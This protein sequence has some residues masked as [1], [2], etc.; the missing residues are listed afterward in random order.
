MS[1]R[2]DISIEQ[3]KE[4]IR[5][6]LLEKKEL[7][8]DLDRNEDFISSSL[9]PAIFFKKR[10][11]NYGLRYRNIIN[12]IPL[13]GSIS[14]KLYNFLLSGS[15]QNANPRPS[16][17]EK[18][19][20]SSTIKN[21]PVLGSLITWAYRLAKAPLR[22]TEL[23]SEIDGL[24]S[25]DEALEAKISK[26]SSLLERF[27]TELAEFIPVVATEYGVRKTTNQ[28]SPIFIHSLWR[29]GST[30][31]WSKFRQNKNCY[32]YYEPFNELL[33]NSQR[34]ALDTLFC[35]VAERMSH[36][37]LEKEYFYESPLL[38]E[39]GNAF[40]RKSFP[41][42]DYCLS[43]DQQHPKLKRYIK[44]LVDHAY[45]KNRTP[46]MQF[47]RSSLRAKWLK[48]NFK[49]VNI[50]LLRFPRAQWKS[51]LSASEKYFDPA[52]F[53]IAGKNRFSNLIKPL[54]DVVA[55]PYFDNDDIVKELK[56]YSD[57]LGEYSLQERYFVFYYIW[58]VSL[59]EVIPLCDLI[60]DMDL[61]SQSSNIRNDVED[62]LKKY[63]ITVDFHDCNIGQYSNF[64][65]SIEEMDQIEKNVQALISQKLKTEFE[66][67]TVYFKN[68]LPYISGNYQIL[69]QSI[70]NNNFK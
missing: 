67:D 23:H 66:K 70:F 30:Y 54:L 33:L 43:E 61:M 7:Y 49:S 9:R 26:L 52:T 47:C 2:Q 59:L 35:N 3:I 11:I 16:T 24:K 45:S 39:G 27:D 8:K 46:V 50:Y 69:L 29:T 34:S 4:K 36:S 1:T 31:I 38:K 58:L 6:S 22:I 56:F 12:K 62:F 64:T 53:L 63:S 57:K 51:Y 41:Y 14:K 25:R 37:M 10:I 13:L 60:I 55:V 68:I 48:K 40:F 18:K 44:Y 28:S 15:M 32:C 17:Q 19:N 65:L 42:D 5:R 21:I 20:F